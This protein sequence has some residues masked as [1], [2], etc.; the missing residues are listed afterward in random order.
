MNLV[1]RLLAVDRK[2]FDMIERKEVPSRQ[3]AK[4]V[5]EGAKVTIQAISGD[6]FSGLSASGLDNDGEVDYG[7]A[8]DTNAKVVA[9]GVVDPDLKN[10]GLQRHMGVAT[11]AEAAKKIFKGEVNRIAAEIARLSGFGDEL[12]ADKEI[13]N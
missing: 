1:E 7:R 2:E 9:A 8:F 4:L 10:E 11:P 13:K 12:E 6:L 3:L 5:G